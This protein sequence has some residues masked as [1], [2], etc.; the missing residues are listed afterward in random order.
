MHV[1]HYHRQ[2]EPDFLFYCYLKTD[3]RCPA[4]TTRFLPP[5][6]FAEFLLMAKS[7][8]IFQYSVYPW[9]SSFS[10]ICARLYDIPFERLHHKVT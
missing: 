7:D 5:D 4:T 3:R 6:T 1:L 8:W 10:E 2:V 9:G